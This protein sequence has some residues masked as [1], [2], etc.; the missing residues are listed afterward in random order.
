MLSAL[1]GAE[2]RVL[3]GGPT[4]ARDLCRSACLWQV[5][6][7]CLWRAVF[8][9]LGASRTMEGSSPRGVELAL[10]PVQTRAAGRAGGPAWAEFTLWEA[11]RPPGAP[12]R[13]ERG[14]VPGARALP[15]PPGAPQCAQHGQRVPV[16]SGNCSIGGETEAQRSSGRPQAGARAERHPLPSHTAP[17]RPTGMCSGGS[18]ITAPRDL[19]QVLQKTMTIAG[20]M[21]HTCDPSGS[22]S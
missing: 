14:S 19:V 3:G 20:M 8:C 2:R 9:G 5:P 15:P 1:A 21:A 16:G 22:G 18:V 13:S 17:P 10:T 12:G 6:E 4:H 11:V 7:E